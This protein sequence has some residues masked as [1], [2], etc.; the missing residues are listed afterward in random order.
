MK[1]QLMIR[2]QLPISV[3]QSLHEIDDFLG[4]PLPWVERI[5]KI[6]DILLKTLAVD[7]IW[8]LT[9]SP[10][11]PT[12]CG[13][14]STPLAIAPDAQICISDKAPPVSENWPAPNTLIGQ[15]IANKQPYFVEAKNST[16][17][18]LIDSDLGDALFATFHSILSAIV[19]LVTEEGSVGVLIVASHEAMHASLSE[20]KRQFLVYLSEHLGTNLHNAYRLERARRHANALRTL[21][22]IAQTITSSLD[23]DE[24]LHRTMAGINEILEVEAGSLLLVD[25]QTGEL[26]FKLT[27]RGE[28]KQITSFR[29]QPGEGIAGWVVTNQQPAISNNAP[30]DQRFCATI[31]DQIGFTTLTVLCVPLLNQGQP[32][33][34]L[35]VINKHSGPFTS[36]DQELLVS[37]SASLGIALRNAHLY[38]EAQDRTHQIET[39]NQIMT[40][41]NTEHGLS[42]TA[43]IIY[44]EFS[45]LLPFDHLS[46]SLLD[47]SKEN[48]RQ[49]IFSEY[50]ANEQTRL[51]IPLKESALAWI[52]E[53]NEGRI[54]G[55]IVSADQ[56][57]RT[58]PDDKI[59][60]E[61]G[62]RSKMA[63]PLTTPKGPYGSLIV[64]HR[65]TNIYNL[66]H[67]NRLRQLIPQVA[68][69]IKKA[70]LT[71]VMEQRTNQLQMLNRLGE[72]LVSMTDLSEMVDISLSMLPRLLP[73]S[74]QGVIVAGDHGVY[75]GVA[76]PFN[77]NKT[78]DII[79]I[80]FEAFTEM[81][82]GDV[83]TEL[84]YSRSIPGNMPVPA[85][86][87]PVTSL[88]FPI[89]TRLGSLGIIYMASD[90]KE[91]LS[92]DLLYIFSLI[93]S[94]IAAG[95][96]N[97][98]LFHQAEQERARLA[99][100]LASST[101]AILVVNK[102]GRIILDNPAAWNVMEV[103]TSRSG[104]LLVDSTAN[105]TLIQLFESAMR[106][107]KSTGEIPLIDGRTYFANLSHV[108]VGEAG[109][110]GWVATMQDVSHFKELNEL[111]NN[112][113][114]AVSH[115]LRSP[116]GGI[117]IASNLMAQVGPVNE[118]QK[119]L[120]DTIHKRVN[121]M[122]DLIDDLLDVGRIEAGLDMELKPHALDTLINEVIL[123]LLPQ[124]EE[125][126]IELKS[127]IAE[128]LP[129]IMANM[130][131]IE[132]VTTNLIGNAIKYTPETG[133]VTVRAC[134]QDNEVR[135]QV[136]D[137]GLG[138]PTTDQPHIFEKFYRV[139]GEHVADI[140]GTG[141]GLAITKGIIEKHNGR[142]WLESVF[143]E[144]STFTVALPA[145]TENG[146]QT[147]VP[148]TPTESV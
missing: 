144:G 82:E 42:G 17:H 41:I 108:S 5:E 78:D 106:G 1:T 98:H 77:F 55:D 139:R 61:E 95:I 56:D 99:A 86:W 130:A 76:V 75:L 69:A 21:N 117:L 136:I 146:V 38:E 53:H 13:S 25:E 46:I 147:V 113:V 48:V 126:S 122:K 145:Y 29:L 140:K 85:D 112:F 115:D 141:L 137:T 83:P 81:S 4:Q 20:D 32:I 50:G 92:D 88:S 19:P 63:I 133:T 8:L 120:L 15:A 35:E 90:R 40:V 68:V 14:I 104:K 54:F 34:A 52:I 103:E 43:K 94:Q 131:R 93:G 127:D 18:H 109:I 132:Q 36:D 72:M 80:M 64:G 129:L 97:A 67:L 12:A 138:I 84:L 22:Q 79:D 57:N 118:T 114:N 134:Q 110:V 33:G 123:A 59:L 10:L 3:W 70:H 71:D 49:W 96:E 7:G 116:L 24:V 119:E 11:P 23:I 87:E 30:N 74:V 51:T 128:D 107:D 124:A 105:E 37:M 28:N 102:E 91:D 66:K 142:I 111:K 148:E 135:L 47:D 16:N 73:G 26:Y 44:Q 121:S 27:L 6:N 39:N 143:G 65:Q 45:H 89:I 9:I 125:K 62:I 100:I 58:Y 60:L 101:D 2:T 31:D